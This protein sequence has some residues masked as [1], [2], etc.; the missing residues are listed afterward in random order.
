MK[1]IDSKSK[2]TSDLD[3]KKGSIF[4][5][6]KDLLTKISTA[7]DNADEIDVLFFKTYCLGYSYTISSTKSTETLKTT[8]GSISAIGK[9]PEQTVEFSG[10]SVRETATNKEEIL[11]T[12]I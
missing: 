2:L 5:Y 9:I 10:Y 6:N 12:Y 1:K 11:D 7:C 3:L 8:C 4:Y